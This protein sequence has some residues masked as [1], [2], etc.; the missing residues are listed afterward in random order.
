MSRVIITSVPTLVAITLVLWLTG[1]FSH[2]DSISD[3]FFNPERVPF[4][5]CSDKYKFVGEV[6][7]SA[8]Q[9]TGAVVGLLSVI[10]GSIWLWEKD[11]KLFGRKKNE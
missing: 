10:F 4:I 2:W 3:G 8:I 11:F 9:V 5:N 7:L 6:F 1:C